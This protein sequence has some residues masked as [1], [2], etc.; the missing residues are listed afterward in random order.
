[1]AQVVRDE[2][3]AHIG[4]YNTWRNENKDEHKELEKRM[5]EIEKLVPAIRAVMWVGAALG[6]SIVGLIWSLVTGQVQ[7]IFR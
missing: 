2:L 3:K 1:L 7:L 4:R 6:L 5:G